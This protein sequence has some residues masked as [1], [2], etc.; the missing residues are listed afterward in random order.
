MSNINP[1]QVN[2]YKYNRQQPNNIAFGH[3]QVVGNAKKAMSA[4]NEAP[5]GNMG[6]DMAWEMLGAGDIDPKKRPAF[7]AG[8]LGLGGVLGTGYGA[9]SD[10]F[11]KT[12]TGN[13]ENSLAGRFN[14]WIAKNTKGVSDWIENISKSK[15]DSGVRSELLDK[16]FNRERPMVYRNKLSMQLRNSERFST[17]QHLTTDFIDE[18]NKGLKENLSQKYADEVK[19]L[20]EFAD[21]EIEAINKR[22][23]DGLVSENRAKKEIKIAERNF[24]KK[25]NGIQAKIS[26]ETKKLEKLKVNFK[27]GKIDAVKARAAAERL[28]KNV[29][30][31]EALNNIK[32]GKSVKVLVN[33][34]NL[35]AQSEK[36]VFSR[37]FTKFMLLFDKQAAIRMTENSNKTVFAERGGSLYKKAVRGIQKSFRNS[38]LSKAGG[39]VFKV[40]GLSSVFIGAPI[41]SGLINKKGDKVN[42]EGKEVDE[43]GKEINTAKNKMKRSTSKFSEEFVG[44]WVFFGPSIRSVYNLA[45]LKNIDPSKA[46]TTLGKFGLKLVKGVGSIFGLGMNSPLSTDKKLKDLYI[47][48]EKGIH[49][50]LVE[51]AIRARKKEL[52]SG[53]TR[54]INTVAIEGGKK[55]IKSTREKVLSGGMKWTEK[56]GMKWGG[57][58]GF[59]IRNV[60]I[61]ALL[62]PFFSEGCKKIAHTVFGKPAQAKTE[63]EKMEEEQEAQQENI[64]PATPVVS[65]PTQHSS[66]SMI[67]EYVD[68]LKHTQQASNVQDTPQTS[69]NTQ[70][71]YKSPM[72]GRY[73]DKM[74]QQSGKQDVIP[75]R[76]MKDFEK[77]EE[78]AKAKIEAQK[79]QNKDNYTYI[80]GVNP[81]QI[82]PKEASQSTI[83]QLNEA[84]RMIKYA[85]KVVENL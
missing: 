10:T 43:S 73:V 39:K 60:A 52:I 51:K 3:P 64:E 80:P 2:N 79:A 33:K 19:V 34:L 46:N 22:L 18:L 16:L 66:N 17:R 14:N 24:N 42:A 38:I 23:K 75:A 25:L 13:I 63:E 84:D 68:N 82:Q 85:E 59:I 36:N 45:N 81:I 6:A 37:A 67:N 35:L 55:V 8:A 20:N 9:L 5:P 47:L 70:A 57:R 78:D 48:K 27:Y 83:N 76:Y 7:V 71:P 11:T 31:E 74:K 32:A 40:I 30:G 29:A 49:T 41:L 56:L 65:S 26:K 28:V 12:S 54:R 77:M 50:R 53:K 72:V 15:N 4:D 61:V 62:Q 44:F 69:N 58:A 1:N 21:K